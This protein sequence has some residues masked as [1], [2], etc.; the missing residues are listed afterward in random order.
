MNELELYDACRVLFGKEVRIDRQFLEYIQPSGVKSAYRKMA[1]ATH[2]DRFAV[3]G[4]N[5]QA[6]TSNFRTVAEAYEKLSKYLKLRESGYRLRAN[7]GTYSENGI[8]RK[9][10]R[11]WNNT[12]T[13]QNNT[14]ANKTWKTTA[15]SYYG[16]S[17]W[18]KASSTNFSGFTQNDAGSNSFDSQKTSSYSYQQRIMP[19]RKLRIGEYLYYSG[20]VGWKDLIASITWQ[21]RQ[22]QRLGEIATRWGWLTEAK[23]LEIM[24]SRNRGERLGDVLVRLKIIT[25]FQCNML[26]WQQQ[27]SQRPLGK[28]FTAGNI[29]SENDLNHHLTNLQ[30]HNKKVSNPDQKISKPTGTLRTV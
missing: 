8:Q 24:K 16:G 12:T 13:A 9:A 1:L 30:S 23:I 11:T 20:V 3:L 7:Y 5:I 29:L 26:I 18:Q 6:D 28:Y 25:P 22:R 4:A 19:R 21:T 27:R 10:A 17:D 14:F 2:P 15:T